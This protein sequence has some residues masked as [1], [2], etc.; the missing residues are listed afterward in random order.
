MR[1]M[2]LCMFRACGTKHQPRQ[3]NQDHELARIGSLL[4]GRCNVDGAG[5]GRGTPSELRDWISQMDCT[6][7]ANR[8]LLTPLAT[9]SRTP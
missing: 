2:V 5:F 9:C 8:N 4:H 7:K 3:R 1:G 6:S